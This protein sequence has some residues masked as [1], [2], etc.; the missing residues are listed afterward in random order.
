M[1]A[2]QDR[3]AGIGAGPLPAGGLGPAHR[4][5]DG[6]DPG[7]AV[8][9]RR[10]PRPHRARDG[11][12]D[13]EDFAAVTATVG[14]ADGARWTAR[15]GGQ[16]GR[17]GPGPRPRSSASASSGPTTWR[18]T[19]RSAQLDDAGQLPAR[20][21]RSPVSD[22]AD[23]H[24]AVD[25]GAGHEITLAERASTP[26]PPTPAGTCAGWR[27][28]SPSPCWWPC[29]SWSPGSGSGS[30]STDDDRSARRRRARGAVAATRARCALAACSSA[31]ASAT[32]RSTAWA[33]CPSRPPPSRRGACVRRPR[34]PSR[35]AEAA[36][37]D[38]GWATASYRPDSPLPPPGAMPEGTFMREIQ[39]RGRLRVGVD[40]NTL[41]FA[42]ATR[43][44]ARSR[45][46]RSSW[47][48]R[49]PSGIFGDA[50]PRRS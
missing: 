22:E 15:H 19:T 48:R 46:S 42:S 37:E 35:P 11:T 8:D 14:G 27:R 9:E 26:T 1:D 38:R 36:C 30:G 3:R 12:S 10:E 40:E 24:A 33:S 2:G 17:R 41:G 13:L 39:E 28:P 6:P 20:R 23:A 44:P 21:R 31:T 43:T 25:Q 5:V 29:C 45:A 47:P 16:P 18:S 4:P 50:R 7:A 49:S 32:T 34:P